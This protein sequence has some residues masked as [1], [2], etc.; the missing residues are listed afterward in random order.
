MVLIRVMLLRVIGAL[1]LAGRWRGCMSTVEL[2]QRGPMQASIPEAVAQAPTASTTASAA[3]MRNRPLNQR[4]LQVLNTEPLSLV[5]S[6]NW[7]SIL[8]CRRPSG[9]PALAKL[10]LL[11][12]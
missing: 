3:A 5:P 9:Q 8:A 2:T 7:V 12:L 11:P 4:P 1:P 6:L 10:S